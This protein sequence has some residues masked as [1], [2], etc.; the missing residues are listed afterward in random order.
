MTLPV[1]HYQPW[2][3]TLQEQLA[4]ARAAEEAGAAVVWAPE[5]HRSAVVTAAALA[6]STV[7]AGVGTGIALAFARSPLLTALSALDLDE[8]SGGRLRLGLGTGVRRLNED[9]HGVA[10]DKPVRRL[11]ETVAAIRLLVAGAHTGERLTF[12]G[13][14]VRLDVRGY[15]RP[16]PPVR[17]HIPIYLAGVGPAMTALAGEVGDGWLSHELC[18]PRYLDATVLPRL[19]AS[20][21]PLEVVV[22]AC[23]AVDDDPAAARAAAANVVGFY[24]SVRTYADL[25][26]F[27]DLAAA[28][29]RVVEAFRAGRPADALADAV[30]PVMVDRLTLA[31][32]PSDVAAR[33]AEYAGLADAVKLG[34]P[35]YGLPPARIRALQENLLRLIRELA[36]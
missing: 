32:T 21:R 33:L 17:D 12:D 16:Y 6:E 19:R 1:L 10:W 36:S 22:S 15:R 24:A 25:F 23:C 29:D 13:A 35:T 4:A 18:P 9:W 28:Q 30:D 2:G 26:A 34:P 7:T 31:G 20:G 11:R 27:F 3:E 14:D 8:L 5:L